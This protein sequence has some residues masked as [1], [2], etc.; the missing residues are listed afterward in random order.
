[1]FVGHNP[2]LHA[3][4]LQIIGSGE[5]DPLRDI[6]HGFSSGT[7]AVVTFQKPRWREIQ[8]GD[9][10]LAHFVSPKQLRDKA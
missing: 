10:H 2:G 3:F 6:A 7:L 4:G 5:R 8:P 9:G 1:M